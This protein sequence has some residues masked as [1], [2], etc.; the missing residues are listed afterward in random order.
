MTYAIE[1]YPVTVE[2]VCSASACWWVARHLDGRTIKAA[3]D[4]VPT[5]NDAV[6]AA[7]TW[8]RDEWALAAIALQHPLVLGEAK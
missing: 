1:G 2:A 3:A 5:A 8:L 7:L 4:N 6:Q